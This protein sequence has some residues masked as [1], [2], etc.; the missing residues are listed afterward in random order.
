MT[1]VVQ[2]NVA[3]T[4]VELSVRGRVHRHFVGAFDSPDLP[5]PSWAQTWYSTPS[6]IPTQVSWEATG[7]W[8]VLT[9]QDCTQTQTEVK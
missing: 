1:V 8:A 3:V 4:T 7:W 2:D 9:Q 5:E 6:P